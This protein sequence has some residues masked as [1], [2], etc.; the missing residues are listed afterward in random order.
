MSSSGYIL[1]C[2]VAGVIFRFRVAVYFEVS[3]SRFIFR[4]RLACV[5]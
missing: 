5:F 4:C 2:H 3:C 1:K